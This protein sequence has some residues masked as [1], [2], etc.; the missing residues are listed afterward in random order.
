[1]DFSPSS[2]FA[3]ETAKGG[4]DRV[5]GSKCV[6]IGLWNGYLD[7]IGA[8]CR[9]MIDMSARTAFLSTLG[10]NSHLPQSQLLPIVRQVGHWLKIQLF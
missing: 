7:G 4:Y 10:A 6:E 5:S 9:T 3:I 1:M 2:E 8:M